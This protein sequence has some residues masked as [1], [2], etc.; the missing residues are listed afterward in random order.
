MNI[1]PMYRAKRIIHRPLMA[2]GV[3]AVLLALLSMLVYG[4]TLDAAFHFDDY[5]YILASDE[6]K[7]PLYCIESLKDHFFRPDRMLVTLSFALNYQLHGFQRPG[8]RL[9]NICLHTLNGL[10]LFVLISSLASIG[11]QKLPLAG[12]FLPAA[13][14]AS[15]FVVHPVA[16]HS[17]TY[18]A[19]R[20]GLAATFFYL[21]GMCCYI[22]GRT[23]T[24]RIRVLF[25]SL[26]AISYW[27]AV[28]CK[29]MALTLPLALAVLEVAFFSHR[30]RREAR[31]SLY[32]AAAF[33]VVSLLLI[34]GYAKESGLFSGNALLAGFRSETLWSPWQ[35]A[36]TE[37]L[38]FWHYLRIVLLPLPIWVAAD[39]YMTVVEHLDWTVIASMLA[40]LVLIGCGWLLVKRGFVLAGAGIALFYTTLAP[41][42]LILPIADVMVDYKTYLPS[43][44]IF[45][46]AAEV[47]GFLIR[48]GRGVIVLS[49]VIFLITS[50]MYLARERTTIFLTEES[51]WTDVIRKYPDQS[52]PYNN[53][54]LSYL[55]DGE[56][57]MA[58]ADFSRAL[59]TNSEY[60]FVHANLGDALLMAGDFAQ[61]RKHY[62]RYVQK[63]PADPDGLVR[64]GNVFFKQNSWPQAI[65]SYRQA[66]ALDETNEQAL[67]NLG[68][69]LSHNGNTLE[70]LEVLNRLVE[71]NDRHYRALTTIGSLHFT[72]K[73]FGLSQSFYQYA[74][75]IEPAYPEALYNMAVLL[76]TRGSPDQAQPFVLRLKALGDP[77]ARSLDDYTGLLP[78]PLSK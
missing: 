14:A 20:H 34:F 42:Y 49:G 35:H 19:Q 23:H 69:A 28:H 3:L 30:N 40:H 33:F 27:A 18:I 54:G 16:V 58:I 13:C 38:V 5:V 73:D 62:E 52:R 21:L 8:Y 11:E 59:N 68:L 39:H 57:D 67:Y 32:I 74:L 61:A 66:V 71:I 70:A 26:L 51:F 10:L 12:R 17:V 63:H 56:Y 29:P 64:L 37:S 46:V 65:T 15:L 2:A 44:G 48:R 50:W 76:I 6:I 36:M 43:I 31:R 53:R 75:K 77:R 24:G 25:F 45:F 1:A 47:I 72:R 9:V 22:A 7:D 4:T 60:E 78:A 41:P 55:K